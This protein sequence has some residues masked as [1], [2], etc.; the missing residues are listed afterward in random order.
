[1]LPSGLPLAT[2]ATAFAP[3]PPVTFSTAKFTFMAG[4]RYFTS[5][6]R[7]TSL[8]PPGLEWVT[9]VTLLCGYGLAACADAVD[10][11]VKASARPTNAALNAIDFIWSPGGKKRCDPHL[12][13]GAAGGTPG[14]VR[15]LGRP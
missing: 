10:I 13:R 11:P 5:S 14:K 1:M 7:N 9:S 2:K 12:K 4:P 3:L 15:G 6:R 8:P